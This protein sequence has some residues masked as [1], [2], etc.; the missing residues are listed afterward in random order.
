MI[1]RMLSKRMAQGVLQGLY[2]LCEGVDDLVL[3]AEARLHLGAEAAQAVLEFVE[4]FIM[5]LWSKER[6]YIRWTSFGRKAHGW[7]SFPVPWS[8][9]SFRP[10]HPSAVIWAER[11]IRSFFPCFPSRLRCE[12]IFPYRSLSLFLFC[13][14]VTVESFLGLSLSLL[15]LIIP[16]LCFLCQ[17]LIQIR[18][19]LVLLLKLGSGVLGESIDVILQIITSLLDLELELMLKGK[20]SVVGPFGLVGNILFAALYFP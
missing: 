13:P 18:N 14:R 9:C 8:S 4:G 16:V 11:A 15:E 20:E 1:G 2:H 17:L 19:F 10:S 3:W 7:Y 12:P 6:S 5:E